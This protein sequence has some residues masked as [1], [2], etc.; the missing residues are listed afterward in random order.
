MKE[1]AGSINEMNLGAMLEGHKY[2]FWTLLN[3]RKFSW[4][5]EY[6]MNLFDTL[7]EYC[8]DETL[9]IFDLGSSLILAKVGEDELNDDMKRNVRS[10]GTDYYHLLDGQHRI[11]FCVLLYAAIRHT[12]KKMLN[13]HLLRTD[14]KQDIEDLIEIVEKRLVAKA[15]RNVVLPRVDTMTSVFLRSLLLPGGDDESSNEP[16]SNKKQKRDCP[17]QK[18]VKIYDSLIERLGKMKLEAIDDLVQFMDGRVRVT[19]TTFNDLARARRMTLDQ[20]HAT[21]PEPVDGYR[22]FL[23]VFADKVSSRKLGKE[24]LSDWDKLCDEVGR[25][26]VR[27]ATEMVARFETVSDE[28][29]SSRFKKNQ[30]HSTT[31]AT[32]LFIKKHSKDEAGLKSVF[33]LIAATATKLSLFQQ[34]KDALYNEYSQEDKVRLMPSLRFLQF[35]AKDRK[36]EGIVILTVSSLILLKDD[37]AKL[38]S[39]VKRLERVALWVVL[40]KPAKKTRADRTFDILETL[41]RF[42]EG[43]T[44]SVDAVD[45]S[46]EEKTAIRASLDNMEVRTTNDRKIATEIL[47]RLNSYIRANWDSPLQRLP[48]VV[49]PMPMPSNVFLEEIF[50]DGEVSSPMLGNYVV[51]TTGPV[52]NETRSEKMSR[53]SDESI[54]CK[55]TQ[56]VG[57]LGQEQEPGETLEGNRDTIMEN[58]DFLWGLQEINQCEK[59]DL[60]DS[61]AV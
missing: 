26:T 27:E 2:V 28:D 12:L 38:L 3:Q 19:E 23:G 54:Q 32:D 8:S 52:K 35:V 44:T 34:R 56:D 16:S 57:V 61:I 59:G 9:P 4:D 41:K 58:A 10:H 31:T 1:S 53:F 60:R 5:E 21:H 15:R 51:T 6:A 55:M 22:G 30:E 45:L 7:I 43:S 40:S 48:N 14:E 24:I 20:R 11:I 49:D 42:S 13:K 25:E 46:D 33:D 47:F 37:T 50:T 36:G 39:F 17:D 18:M 29:I